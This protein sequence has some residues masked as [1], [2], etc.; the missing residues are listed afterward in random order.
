MVASRT[1]VVIAVLETNT[2]VVQHVGLLSGLDQRLWLELRLFVKVVGRAAV[3]KH[4]PLALCLREKLGVMLSLEFDQT[5]LEVVYKCLLAPWTLR[6]VRNR[7]K[8]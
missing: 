3:H 2:D 8:G 6:G 7:C 4:M 5:T 1:A